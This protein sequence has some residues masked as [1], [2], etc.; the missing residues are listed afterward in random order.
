MQKRTP[1][2]PFLSFGAGAPAQ[3]PAPAGAPRP[4]R[5]WGRSALLA[6]AAFAGGAAA[7]E[8]AHAT[9]ERQNPYH[10]MEQ[11]GRVLVAIEDEYVDPVDRARLIEGGIKGM[12]AEL[13]PHSSY[14]P[15]EDY[16]IFQGDLEGRFGGVGVEVDFG[17]D[18]VTV[19]AP[20]EGSPAHQAGVKSGDRIF[21]IDNMAVRG[22]SPAELVRAMR[23]DPGTKVILT[24]RREGVEQL[25]TFVLVRRTISVASIASKLLEGN[26]GYLRIKAFQSGTHAEL[27]SHVGKLRKK[28]RGQLAGVVLDLRNNPGGSVDEANA[29]ADEFLSSGVIFTTRRRGKVIDES[30]AD[31]SGA[32]RRQPTVVLVNEF[33]AS[34]SELVAAALRDNARARIVGAPTF[35]K[36]SVQMIADLPGGAG[37]RLTTLRYYTPSGRAIQAE[38]VTPDVVVNAAP[39]DF[40]IVREKNLENHLPA[41]E[42][43]LHDA[44][45]PVTEV[46]RADAGPKT[47]DDVDHG[48]A[49]DVPED[50]SKGPD[51][52]L[53]VAHRLLKEAVAA[54]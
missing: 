24:I 31:T 13:D 33:S 36:G 2:L 44:V 26:F 46:D 17:G 51:E 41:S 48:V 50:P 45:P 37:L 7:S 15:P 25:M 42:G 20:I 12:V 4:Q 23:G 18:F 8:L 27:L 39:S 16:T 54:R 35:G 30:R 10:L 19:I 38:G 11:L 43:A 52:A 1:A 28:A 40:G 47:T 34:A 3:A 29:I 9:T 14:L 32:L 53:K 49:R 5:R 22:R 21:A 6:L